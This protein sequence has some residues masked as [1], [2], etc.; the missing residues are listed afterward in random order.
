MG[1]LEGISPIARAREEL[2]VGNHAAAES[3]LTGMLAGQ[4]EITSHALFD[5]TGAFEDL[6]SPSG[7]YE[8]LIG[9][10]S[11]CAEK[12]NRLPE[13]DQQIHN[14]NCLIAIAGAERALGR[15]KDA[16]RDA[17]TAEQVLSRFPSEH[18]GPKSREKLTR[19]RLRLR[20]LRK[21]LAEDTRLPQ[22]GNESLEST[23]SN[24]IV[25]WRTFASKKQVSPKEIREYLGKMHAACGPTASATTILNWAMDTPRAGRIGATPELLVVLVE[26][27]VILTTG[28]AL[29]F[30]TR[31]KFLCLVQSWE[32]EQGQWLQRL[33][34]TKPKLGLLDKL[35]RLRRGLETQFQNAVDLIEKELDKLTALNS[36]EI[37][38]GGQGHEATLLRLDASLT[39]LNE[40]VP[41]P[42]VPRLGTLRA[43]LDAIVAKVDRELHRRNDAYEELLKAVEQAPDRSVITHLRRSVKQQLPLAMQTRPELEQAFRQTDDRL[44]LAEVEAIEKQERVS[45]LARLGS[46]HGINLANL[47]FKEYGIEITTARQMVI[48]HNRG[49][50]DLDRLLDA[51]LQIKRTSADQTRRRI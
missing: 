38:D 50:M 48:D 11:R 28:H 16:E 23:A 19:L 34:R 24:Q 13:I 20:T 29:P 21:A 42:F 44:L 51:V 5:L 2:R 9:F 10:V 41:S 3:I 39:E 37:L 25:E 8:D 26:H 4:G 7:R 6:C 17:R 33:S 27:L 47:L 18:F 14:A 49:L 15:R 32:K 36:G 35:Q 43:S 40:G 30:Y 46:V 1:G 31:N 22:S 45:H 12:A